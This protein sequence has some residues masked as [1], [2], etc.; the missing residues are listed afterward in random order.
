[1]MYTDNKTDFYEMN[2]DIGML[3]ISTL[4]TTP[5]KTARLKNNTYNFT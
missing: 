3:Y 5:Q 2:N 4:Q 1:M